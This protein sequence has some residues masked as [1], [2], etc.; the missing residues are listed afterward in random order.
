MLENTIFWPV[1]VGPLLGRLSAK[2]DVAEPP[3]Q[4]PLSTHYGHLRTRGINSVRTKRL[5]SC[6]DRQKRVGGGAGDEVRWHIPI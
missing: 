3:G 1:A 5:T 2:A 4:C 6:G